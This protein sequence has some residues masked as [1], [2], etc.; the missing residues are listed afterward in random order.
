MS[1]WRTLA[2][3]TCLAVA[4]LTTSAAAQGQGQGPV[5]TACKDEIAT[6][7]AGLEHGQG[8]VRKCLESNKEK[9]SPACKTALETTGPGTGMGGGKGPA[10]P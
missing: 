7:C 8:A 9:V 2:A 4:A 1:T 10:K 5:A 6:F 3:A